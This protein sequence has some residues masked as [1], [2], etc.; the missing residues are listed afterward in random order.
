MWNYV[1]KDFIKTSNYFM[2]SLWNVHSKK[3]CHF[4]CNLKVYFKLD[5]L[6]LDCILNGS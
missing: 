6:I 1:L 3:K 4:S 5:I 2:E